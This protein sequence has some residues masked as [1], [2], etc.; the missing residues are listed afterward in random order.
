M[1]AAAAVL[2]LSEPGKV[3][4]MV[5]ACGKP[6]LVRDDYAS[7]EKEE[8]LVPLSLYRVGCHTPTR[9]KLH[10]LKVPT[11]RAPSWVPAL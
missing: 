9:P 11:L 3:A 2:L 4:Q 8:T 6:Q 7:Q 10:L 5:I 1:S